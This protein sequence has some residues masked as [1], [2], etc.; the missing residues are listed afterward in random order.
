LATLVVIAAADFVVSLVFG[1]G[2]PQRGAA[3][4]LSVCRRADTV[5]EAK[6]ES[7]E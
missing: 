1:P 4:P 6:M 3:R 5:E 2:L 7:V